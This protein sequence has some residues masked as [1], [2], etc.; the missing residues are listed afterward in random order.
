VCVCV[1]VCMCVLC[2]CWWG[3]IVIVCV[4]MACIFLL[5]WCLSS[6]Y[7]SP[8]SKAWHWLAGGV[9]CHGMARLG[10][11]VLESEPEPELEPFVE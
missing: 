3:V 5:A 8:L 10:G 11:R 4:I 2:V 7:Q 6:Y 1:R 9:P